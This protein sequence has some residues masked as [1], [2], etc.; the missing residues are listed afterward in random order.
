MNNDRCLLAADPRLAFSD[1]WRMH[2]H[3]VGDFRTVPTVKYGFSVVV[4]VAESEER[5][6]DDACLFYADAIHESLEKA[7]AASGL[8]VA[9]DFHTHAEFCV[10]DGENVCHLASWSIAFGRN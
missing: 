1:A 9:S 2:R 6:V 3:Y 7:A 8:M 4:G 5:F 10:H